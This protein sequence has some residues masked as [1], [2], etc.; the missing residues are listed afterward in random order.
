M[1]R[2]VSSVLIFLVIAPVHP[3]S[4]ANVIT[5]TG[6]KLA[7]V[8][9]QKSIV[10]S[11]SDLRNLGENSIV[12]NSKIAIKYSQLLAPITNKYLS[13]RSAAEQKVTTSLADLNRNSNFVIQWDNFEACNGRCIKGSVYNFPFNAKDENAQSGFDRNVAIG[14][15]TPQDKVAYDKAREAYKIALQDLV[16]VGDAYQEA[17]YELGKKIFAEYDAEEERLKATLNIQKL[18][19]AAA[20]RASL[21]S[22]DFETN[23]KTAFQFQYNIDSLYLVGSAS[24]SQIESY[25]DALNVVSASQA[26]ALGVG[27]SKNYQATKAASFNKALGNAFTNET[28]FRSL[29]SKALS[30]YRNSAK[31]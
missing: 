18:A 2:L 20:K 3:A 5:K 26:Y 7:V 15:I 9:I 14:V 19:L 4:A 10:K 13:D 8:N 31:K 11:T 29:Y 28:E 12:G 6:A 21:A 24:F 23:F 27:I 25:L 22:R 1:K 30:L 16:K 17:D